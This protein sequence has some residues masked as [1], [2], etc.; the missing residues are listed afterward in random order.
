MEVAGGRWGQQGRGPLAIAGG[1]VCVCG[2]GVVCKPPPQ[3]LHST[4][5]AV[6]MGQTIPGR[7]KVM[8][9]T[10]FWIRIL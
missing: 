6:P 8:N 1:G 4:L 10:L 2:W 5:G 3:S 7:N 9:V